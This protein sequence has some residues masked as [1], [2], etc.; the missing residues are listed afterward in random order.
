M[1]SEILPAHLIYINVNKSPR[2]FLITSI[3][4]PAEWQLGDQYIKQI[5]S[6]WKSIMYTS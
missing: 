4:V 1:K 3:L 2:S 5:D 6:K